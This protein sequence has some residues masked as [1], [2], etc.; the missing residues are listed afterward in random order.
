MAGDPQEE[1]ASAALQAATGMATAATESV[2]LTV[3]G[4]PDVL[5]CQ[6]TAQQCGVR[7][8]VLDLSTPVT[9]SVIG[10]VLVTG[11]PATDVTTLDAGPRPVS[12][13][14]EV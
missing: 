9:I 4:G 11:V 5:A 3:G 10:K 7:A 13:R 8:A 6:A 14:R 2:I 12:S 1:G